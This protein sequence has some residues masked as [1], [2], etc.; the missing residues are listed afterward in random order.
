MKHRLALIFINLTVISLML[1]GQSFAKIDPE[2][3]MA[4]WLFDEGKG[5]VAEDSSGNGN[6]GELMKGPS[7]VDGKFGKALEFDGS[8]DAVEVPDSDSL[9]DVDDL[10]MMAWVYLNRA[11]TSGSWNALAGKKPYASG[12]LMWIEVPREPCGLVYSPGRSDCRAGVQIDVEKWYHLVF[13]RVNDGDMKFFIDGELVKEAA[14]TPGAINVQTA[15]I[16][17]AGQSP[18]VLDGIVDDVAIFNVA[19]SEDDISSIMKNG[20]KFVFAVDASDK[21]A[22]VWGAIKTQ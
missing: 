7:W 17:I 15:P 9:N 5:E 3:C 4:M 13:T 11:V 6:N 21:L 14:S 1:I 12:Y 10:T 16:S 19:L 2:T 20:L 18:Q 8:D 22:G